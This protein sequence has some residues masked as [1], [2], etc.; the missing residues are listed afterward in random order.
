MSFISIF[1]DVLGPIMRGPSSSH[2]AGSYHIAS[3]AR[4]LLQGDIQSAEINFLANGSYARVYRQQG[5]DLAFIAGLLGRPLTDPQYFQGLQTAEANGADISFG[6]RELSDAGHPNTV[7]LKLTGRSSPSVTLQ[8]RSVGGGMIE[9]TRLQNRPVYLNGKQHEVVVFG[10]PSALRKMERHFTTLHPIPVIHT[11]TPEPTTLQISLSAPLQRTD[12]RFIDQLTGIDSLWQIPPLF[13]IKRGPSLFED[14]EELIAVAEREE[15]SMGQAAMAEESSL[16]GI[17]HKEALSEMDHRLQ[18]MEESIL[19]GMDD[20]RANMKL[21]SPSAA[22]IMAGNE[23]GGL[24]VGGL[25]SRA[26]AR[27]MAVMHCS[28]S[29]GVVCAA[30][31]GG[32]AG[33]LPAII[34][35]LAESLHLSREKMVMGLFAAG[36]IGTIIAR[37]ATFA[38]EVAGCQVE[39]GAATAM[40][41]AATVELT[42]GNVRQAADAAAISLQNT[43]GS[44][45][46][47]VQGIC[48]IPCH[49][50]N[51]IGASSALVCADLI[52][53]GYQN[54]IPLDETIDAVY[55]VG[56]M[57]PPEL[58]CTATGG[59][60]V[61]PTAKSMKPAGSMIQDKDKK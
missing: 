29:G 54:P 16:L 28:N 4:E 49:T 41:A 22:S 15:W 32:S 37:R 39:I 59:L 36:A 60:A 40:G 17:T 31:T 61:T 14:Y 26:A 45:C 18:I 10:R 27:A 47:L 58:R 30:P 51:G 9:V 48:E 19:H 44:V 56:Q 34:T 8:A 21:L 38:A 3:L 43:M 35:T 46:D 55:S 33:T 1:N 23:A 5:A 12:L 2:T 25:H 42:G 50:R 11:S 53:G 20:R 6:E 57:L 52:M 7:E 13:R 24:A